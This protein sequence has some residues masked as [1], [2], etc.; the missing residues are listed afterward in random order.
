MGRGLLNPTLC[1]CLIFTQVIKSCLL[2]ALLPG[3]VSGGDIME[4]SREAR[5]SG[6]GASL[7]LTAIPH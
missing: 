2:V 4:E 5:E 6:N 1:W 7:R 3:S